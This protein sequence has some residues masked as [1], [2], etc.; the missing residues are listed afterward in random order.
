VGSVARGSGRH[1]VKETR[2]FGHGEGLEDRGLTRRRL[3][4]L[5]DLAGR[6]DK[7][8]EV[9]LFELGA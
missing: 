2:R 4:P 7:A 9:Q 3:G 1:Q 8:P 5:V 6:P